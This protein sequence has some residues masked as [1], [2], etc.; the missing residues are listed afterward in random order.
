M[1]ILFRRIPS[2]IIMYITGILEEMVKRFWQNPLQ[3]PTYAPRL[4]G[5]GVSSD[6][7]IK[8]QDAGIK[9]RPVAPLVGMI[10][11]TL[12][13]SWLLKP[14][15]FKTIKRYPYCFIRANRVG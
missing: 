15:D 4:P 9:P 11:T 1:K 3:I 13:A 8:K 2:V 14:E 10:T 12:S 7:C 6:K 5:V